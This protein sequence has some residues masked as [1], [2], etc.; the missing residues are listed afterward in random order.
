[1][2]CA[3]ARKDAGNSFIRMLDDSEFTVLEDQRVCSDEACRVG[4]LF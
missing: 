2:V 1:M 3:K 4:K